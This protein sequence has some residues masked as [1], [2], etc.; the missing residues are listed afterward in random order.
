MSRLSKQIVIAL[1]FILII[2]LPVILFYVFRDKEAVIIQE[3][4]NLSNLTLTKTKAVKVNQDKYDLIARIKNPNPNHG[5]KDFSYSFIFI[6]ESGKQVDEF[7]GKGY[8]LPS[9]TKYL[10]IPGVK[11]KTSKTDFKFKI[12]EIEWLEFTDSF[13]SLP[14]FEKNLNLNQP[15]EGFASFDGVVLNKGLIRYDEVEIIIILLDELDE[16]LTINFTTLPTISSGEKKNFTL[17]WSEPFE[18]KPTKF[19]IQ[20]YVNPF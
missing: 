16:I 5:A 15:S 11:L 6:D 18:G 2:S 1:I 20:A 3:K 7:K 12:N 10:V 14:I 19:D 8:I 13:P 4:P 17:I 9:E